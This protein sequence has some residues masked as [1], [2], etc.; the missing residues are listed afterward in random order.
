MKLE[1]PSLMGR[2]LAD[3]LTP[4][5]RS[6]VERAIQ[7]DPELLAELEATA[8]LKL[9]LA[10]LRELGNLER[11][12]KKSPYLRMARLLLPLV[13][14]LVGV[15]IG[16]AVWRSAR[17]PTTTTNYLARSPELLTQRAGWPLP[18]TASIAVFRKRSRLDAQVPITRGAGA[19]QL[20]V[21]ATA[22]GPSANHY[23]LRLAAI[24]QGAPPSSVGIVENLMA[25]AD[26]F[27][28]AYVDAS[29]LPFGKYQ[30]TLSEM[31]SNGSIK[32]KTFFIE[33]IRSTNH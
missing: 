32:T 5:E 30:L 4:Q 12:Q 17:G 21:L 27:V 2:Y 15:A 28:T 19:V 18:I 33:F 7:Q 29:H 9:G 1:D 22:D 26:G 10:R 11:P 20:R 16:V 14:A 25:A 6:D 3:Q 31:G 13:A 8:R 23:R 24:R